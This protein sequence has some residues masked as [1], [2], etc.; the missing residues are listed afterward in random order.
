MRA[1][2]AK[3]FFY[4]T[5]YRYPSPPGKP[6]EPVPPANMK[7]MTTHVVKSL[8]GSISEGARVPPGE[9]ALVGVA[10]SGEARIARVDI[11]LDGGAT[12][13]AAALDAHDSDYGFRVFR[14]RATVTPGT[15]VIGSRATDTAGATQPAQPV[16]NPAGYLHNAID[17]A[18]VEVR[19]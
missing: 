12:W 5:G 6:G 8:I 9:L 16:W 18:R 11:T 4:E 2:E 3:G 7:V 17:L 14:H 13:T 19:A 1:D 15:L 10:F